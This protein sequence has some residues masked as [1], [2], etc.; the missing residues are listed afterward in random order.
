[1]TLSGWKSRND[2]PREGAAV[3]SASQSGEKGEQAP[4]HACCGGQG[5]QKHGHQNGETSSDQAGCCG[6]KAAHDADRH[7]HTCCGGKD[8]D[9]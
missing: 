9:D 7:D 8:R 4:S 3:L 1:M 2:R 5:H 6:G